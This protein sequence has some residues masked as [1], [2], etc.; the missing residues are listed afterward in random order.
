MQNL[1]PFKLLWP[2]WGFK[3]G[4]RVKSDRRRLLDQSHNWYITCQ[5]PSHSGVK[6]P[7]WRLLHLCKTMLSHRLYVQ[8][9]VR[10]VIVEHIV[11][12]RDTQG[13]W[14]HPRQPQSTKEKTMFVLLTF[15]NHTTVK[16]SLFPH[17][18]IISF[19]NFEF[20]YRRL[21]ATWA[22]FCLIIN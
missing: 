9:K 2:P 8:L 18:L 3:I 5:G 17:K 10:V 19:S 21:L 12:S 11:C 14:I 22:L 1:D 6:F 13:L 20:A 15:T 4:C 7:L 16:S